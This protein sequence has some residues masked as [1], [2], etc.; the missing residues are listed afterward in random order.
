MERRTVSGA[1]FTLLLICTLGLA[2]ELQPVESESTA[3][4]RVV[5]ETSYHGFPSGEFTVAVVV[6]DVGQLYALQIDMSWNATLLDCVSHVV[7]APV[8]THSNGILHASILILKDDVDP[9]LGT[10]EMAVSSIYPAASF[11][12]SGTVFEITFEAK[13]TG[14]CV[15]QISSILVDYNST[16]IEHNV[17]DGAVYIGVT[18]LGDVDGDSDV[19]IFDIVTI[20]GAY[21][22]NEGDVKYLRGCDIDDDNDVDIYDMVIAAGNYGI[23]L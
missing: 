13:T 17:A 5:P 7:T 23:A 21:G 15:L 1:A 4:V 14:T 20:A 6:E 16:S 19:D 10:Y 12:G 18:I 3:C 11:N 9:A 2:V 22:S 8:E